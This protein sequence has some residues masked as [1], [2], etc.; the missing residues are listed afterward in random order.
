MLQAEI[1]KLKLDMV[2]L[3]SS[4]TIIEEKSAWLKLKLEQTVFGFA[5]EKKEL[6]AAY[7]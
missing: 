2:A 1:H 6:K 5:K 4:K 7:Q 3:E